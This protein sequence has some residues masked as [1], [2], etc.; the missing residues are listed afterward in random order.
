MKAD[1]GVGLVHGIEAIPP[2]VH[3]QTGGSV[4]FV[5]TI[6]YRRLGCP[7]VFSIHGHPFDPFKP[8]HDGLQGKEGSR[9]RV[10][11]AAL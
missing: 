2:P 11:G 6:R 1:D 4:G 8:G 10:I 9:L 5:F 3:G 7:E